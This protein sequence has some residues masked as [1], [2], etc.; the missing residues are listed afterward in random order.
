[1][2]LAGAVRHRPDL[3]GAP[4]GAARRRPARA[5][6]AT[7]LRPR[8]RLALVAR[9]RLVLP[10]AARE[11]AP[12]RFVTGAPA[13]GAGSWR[14]RRR[15]FRAASSCCTCRAGIRAAPGAAAR[16][17][18][19]LQADA[20]GVRA[21]HARDRARRRAGRAG[22]AAAAEGPRQPL[23]LLEL[24]R[25][26]DRGGHGEAAI[27]A[28]MI[29]KVSRWRRV[30]RAR[31]IVAGMSAGGALAAVMGLRYPDSSA[32]SSSTRAW[33]AARRSRR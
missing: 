32:A 25:R 14:P 18:P 7:C 33:P 12:G 29:R 2:L 9:R 13:P 10:A 4:A 24:V 6:R 23:A 8:F 15:S 16:V 31:V 17:L 26:R 19:R 30:D 20:R 28:A 27:V 5:R 11:P 21:G 3:T 1:M 22:A